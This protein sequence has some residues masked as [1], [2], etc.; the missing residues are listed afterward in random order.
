VRLSWIAMA[1]Y[2][3]LAMVK[4]EKNFRVTER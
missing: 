2:L 1:L 3:S 4:C